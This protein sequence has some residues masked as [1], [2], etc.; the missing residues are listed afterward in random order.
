[1][2]RNNKTNYLNTI[3]YKITPKEPKSNDDCYFGYC[4]TS[5][6]KRLKSHK[7]AYKEYK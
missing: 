7:L 4:T 3:I 6:S 1:M 5:L 2:P